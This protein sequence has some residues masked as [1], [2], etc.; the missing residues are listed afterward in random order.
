MRH[1]SDA[2]LARN[3]RARKSIALKIFQA[4]AV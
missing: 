2:M 1:Q 3:K 4:P